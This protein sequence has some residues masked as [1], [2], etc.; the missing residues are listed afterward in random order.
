MS[1]FLQ[2]DPP[3]EYSRLDKLDGLRAGKPQPKYEPVVGDQIVV[4][5][6]THREPGPTFAGRL[7]YLNELFLTISDDPNDDG[8]ADY[9][10]DLI[11][12]KSFPFED[13]TI[14]PRLA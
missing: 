14:T 10:R 8:R 12:R 3:P 1:P 7:V 6:W 4:T 13:V 5:T 9:D 2:S 11:K